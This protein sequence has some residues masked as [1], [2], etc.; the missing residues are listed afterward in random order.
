MNITRIINLFKAYFIEYKK[1]LLILSI[2]IFAVAMLESIDGLLEFSVALHFG[3]L[4]A[5]AGMFFQPSL[6]RNNSTHFFNLP[7]TAGEKLAH[8]IVVLVTLT[9]V[10]HIIT[11]AGTYAGYYLIRPIF[12]T[13]V[14][15]F[16]VNGMSILEESIWYLEVYFLFAAALSTFLFGS[17]YFKKMALFKTMAFGV[18]L[19]LII[20]PLYNLLLLFIAFGSS[21]PFTGG[22]YSFEITSSVNMLHTSF[23]EGYTYIILSVITLFFL[24]L[25]YLR[26]KETE[27]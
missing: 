22:E 12:N 5:V 21:A 18:G 23:Y 4:I 6:K 17:I 10:F 8:A 1:K 16:V 2:I 24:S 3:I 14:N 11:V 20:L 15:R 25:T 27:V 26:L 19:L 13:G 9:V 7:V